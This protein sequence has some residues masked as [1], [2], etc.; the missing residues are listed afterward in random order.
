MEVGLLNTTRMIS[1]SLHSPCT[2]QTLDV[3]TSQKPGSRLLT[4]KLS[5]LSYTLR[6]CMTSWVFS[7]KIKSTTCLVY[8]VHLNSCYSNYITINRKYCRFTNENLHTTVT[9]LNTN[10]V[11]FGSYRNSL[12]LR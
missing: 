5:T 1:L 10:L 11:M 3:I 8:S 7:W 6:L 9:P 4:Q 12:C 2:R